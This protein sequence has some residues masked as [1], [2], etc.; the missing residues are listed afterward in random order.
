[1]FPDFWRFKEW[2]RE[3]DQFVADGNLPALELVRLPHDHF[4]SFG[5]AIDGVNTPELQMADND[6]AV[7]LV[8]DKVSHSRFADDTLIFVIEDDAQDGPDHIDAHRSTA[9]VAGPYVR[10]GAVVSTPMTT[11]SMV[12]T[13]EDVLGLE[14]MG[15]TDGLSAPM[16]DVFQFRVRPNDWSFSAIV[17]ATLRQTQLPL[18][19]EPMQPGSAVLAKLPAPSVTHTAAYWSRATA[20]ENFD[21]EDAV[22]AQRFNRTLWYGLRGQSVPYPTERHGRDMSVK[23]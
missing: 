6:Y 11:V 23:R 5:T 21:R 12:R 19:P 14:H 2:E 16:T 20:S 1:K 7:A 10:R 4:G 18:P 3:F 13:I 15:L 8:V 17:P 9:F 22:D